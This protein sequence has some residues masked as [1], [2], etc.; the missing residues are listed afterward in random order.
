[1]RVQLAKTTRHTPVGKKVQWPGV[2]VF[3]NFPEGIMISAYS[4]G[5]LNGPLKG[6]H[7]EAHW[8]LGFGFF[9]LF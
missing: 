9:S 6:A 2:L 5:G 8:R 3:E 7:F 4:Q 1:M